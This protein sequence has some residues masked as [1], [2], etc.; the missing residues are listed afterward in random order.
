MIDCGDG[1]EGP[2]H[3]PDHSL[4]GPS[5]SAWLHLTC[6]HRL[7][8]PSGSAWLTHWGVI[9]WAAG[10]LRREDWRCCDLIDSLGMGCGASA[11]GDVDF[12]IPENTVVM[13]VGESPHKGRTGT[14]AKAGPKKTLVKFMDKIDA[15]EEIMLATKLLIATG[16]A[17]GAREPESDSEEEEEDEAERKK[18]ERQ[19]ARERKAAAA[20]VAKK[21]KKA[22][23]EASDGRTLELERDA[24]GK[25]V[26]AAERKH[27]SKK[28]KL[29]D[30]R[31]AKEK[32]A[33]AE[34]AASGRGTKYKLNKERKK[35]GLDVSMIS[36]NSNIKGASEKTA[37]GG[38]GGGAKSQRRLG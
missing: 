3:V 34:K 19:Q 38:T 1:I 32:E 35:G 15:D 10:R 20:K 28:K 31:T 5:C 22:V 29:Q 16:P 23:V 37:G 21:G 4:P 30:G 25:V 6:D 7:S 13:V 2:V 18:R 17:G 33:A 12:G 9:G 11:G 8:G 36:S 24:S 27:K 14:I 26:I